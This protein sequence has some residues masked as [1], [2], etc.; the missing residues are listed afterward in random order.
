MPW[1]GKFRGVH[2]SI[3]C[4]M[5]IPTS[6]RSPATLTIRACWGHSPACRCTTMEASLNRSRM[7]RRSSST[8]SAC[9]CNLSRAASHAI[10][11]EPIIAGPFD[12]LLVKPDD[13]ISSHRIQIK[14]RTFIKKFWGHTAT[15]SCLSQHLVFLI[16]YRSSTP[17]YLKLLGYFSF[18]KIP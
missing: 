12:Q 16:R 4:S 6:C 14:L 1:T 18:C 3:F 5:Q 13:F 17:I 11:V 9:G 2:T 15:K 7:A 10:L 8:V